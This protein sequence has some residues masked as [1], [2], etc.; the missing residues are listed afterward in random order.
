MTATRGLEITIFQPRMY[1]NSEPQGAEHAT[2]HQNSL[3][4]LSQTFQPTLAGQ[5]RMAADKLPAIPE[6][7]PGNVE[8]LQRPR[9]PVVRKL[10]S[11]PIHGCGIS[12]QA[13]NMM[14][15]ACSGRPMWLGKAPCGSLS[16]SNSDP[17]W[18]TCHGLANA[19]FRGSARALFSHDCLRDNNVSQTLCCRGMC[20]TICISLALIVFAC[21][22]L[23][24]GMCLSMFVCAFVS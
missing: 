23:A 4:Y 14:L 9:G 18:L 15:D 12:H 21:H 6:I 5:K 17:S 22:E 20:T 11:E 1:L 10:R 2:Y 16:C 13:H 8:S 3:T 7:L 19:L 24:F